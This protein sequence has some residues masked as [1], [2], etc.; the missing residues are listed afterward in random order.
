M[1]ATSNVMQRPQRWSEPF[2]PEMDEAYVARVLSLAPFSNMDASKF[3]GR[4]P[5]AGILKNDCR[6]L[7]FEKGDLVVRE[8]DYGSSAF[9]IISGSVLVSLKSLPPDILGRV[10]SKRKSL[11][12]SLSQLW[13]NDTFREVRRYGDASQQLGHRNDE[14]G[15]RVFLNDIPRVLDL[16]KTE[17]M[18]SGEIFGELSALTRTPRSATVVADRETQILEI[19]WQGLRD[20]M[21]SDPALKRHVEQQYRKFSLKSHLREVELLSKLEPDEISQIADA[22]EFETFGRFQWNVDYRSTRKKDIAERILDEPVIVNQGDYVNAIYLIRTGF[23][24]ICRNHGDGIQTVAF[25]G[26]GGVFG[27]REVTHNWKFKDSQTPW[28]LSLRAVGYV[29][30]LR[31]PVETVEEFVLNRLDEKDMIGISTFE[32]PKAD[33]QRRMKRDHE[34]DRGLLEFLVEERLANGKKAMMIDLNRCTRCDDCVR[35]C[36]ATHNNNPRFVREGLVHNNWMI[37][38][39]CMHCTDPVCMIG[40]PT[41]AIGRDFETGNVTINDSTCIG[42]STCANSCPYDNIRMV[43]INDTSGRKI[44]DQNTKEPILKATKCDF[45]MD[46]LVGP[47]CQRAC[48]HDA[49][50]RIDLTDPTQISEWSR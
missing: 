30:M 45:C 2:D 50:V 19:R 18:N 22:T 6:I 24:R 49:L 29:D 33:S 4:T 36:A 23:V 28:R 46:Q 48:P 38:N 35:A 13:S 8:G 27:L 37:T 42:C 12:E 32:K 3:P 43:E 44:L 21:R 7:H 31:I 9:F 20:L 5:L 14:Q 16:S 17:A 10:Q 40:C 11:F 34:M 25:M 41:G 26:K 47:A 1:D 15:T 39:A